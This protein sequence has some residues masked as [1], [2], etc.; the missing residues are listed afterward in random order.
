MSSTTGSEISYAGS[1]HAAE[2]SDLGEQH[3]HIAAFYAQEE[4]HLVVFYEYQQ[5]LLTNLTHQRTVLACYSRAHLALHE[6]LETLLDLQN[7]RSTM[8]VPVYDALFASLMTVVQSLHVNMDGCQETFDHLQVE[9][10][11][12]EETL[13]DLAAEI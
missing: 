4:D 7:N 12:L 8:A 5:K 1:D 11:G 13:A 9:A 10:C 6:S 2:L 3:P